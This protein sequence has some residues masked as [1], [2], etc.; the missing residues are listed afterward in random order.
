M[1]LGK[2]TQKTKLIR[3][4]MA[5]ITPAKGTEKQSLTGLKFNKYGKRVGKNAKLIWQANLGLQ[6]ALFAKYN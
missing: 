4:S 2:P 6:L 1:F 3:Q 5:Q